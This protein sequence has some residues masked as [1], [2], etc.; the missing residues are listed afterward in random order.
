MISNIIRKLNSYLS[1]WCKDNES[2]NEQKDKLIK[3]YICYLKKEIL[4]IF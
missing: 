1:F 4:K 3:N 2:I